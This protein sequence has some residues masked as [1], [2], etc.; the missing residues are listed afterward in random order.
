M[1]GWELPPRISGGLGVACDGLLRGLGKL[2]DVSTT[3]ILPKIWQSHSIYE[4]RTRIIS[5]DCAADL[6]DTGANFTI[7]GNRREVDGYVSKDSPAYCSAYDEGV[8]HA[9][10]EY[11]LAVNKISASV[12][13]FDL[14]HAHD[15]LTF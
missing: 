13:R 7:N 11:S 6:A 15:W 1:L 10:R 2:A 4:K 8:L 5:L 14:I 9:V 12:G 3:F